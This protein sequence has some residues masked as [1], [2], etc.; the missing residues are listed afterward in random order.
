MSEILELRTT[1]GSITWF[2]EQ[3]QHAKSAEAR[4]CARNELWLR[5]LEVARSHASKFL[6]LY[7]DEGDIEDAANTAIEKFA[8]RATEGKFPELRNRQHFFKLLATIAARTAKNLMRERRAQKRG[9]GVKFEAGDAIEKVDDPAATEQI[10]RFE[11]MEDFFVFLSELAEDEPMFR[12]AELIHA[13]S[14]D[15]DD[16]NSLAA[17]LGTSRATVYR[18]LAKLRAKWAEFEARMLLADRSAS[19]GH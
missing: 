8:N 12:L 10:L 3:L 11:Q 19:G 4:E 6:T 2:L 17:R 16:K 18:K 13:E 5:G 15:T 7:R 9:G 14:V 1:I